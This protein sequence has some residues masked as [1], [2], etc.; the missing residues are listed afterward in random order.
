[1]RIAIACMSFIAAACDGDDA[2][3]GADTAHH[4]SDA[5]AGTAG[6]STGG[7]TPVASYCAC[8]LSS[9]HDLYHEL[10]GEDEIA[11]QQACT[12][13]AAV[14]PEAGMDV[15]AGNFL[16]CRAHFCGLASED[17]A[18]CHA[19]AGHVTCVAR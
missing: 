17:E 7:A 18:Q 3:D 14:L 8:M 9:C 12:D 15:Q 13:E 4:D 11:A 10:W 19:A 5:H 2:S 6:D 16:E 1:M